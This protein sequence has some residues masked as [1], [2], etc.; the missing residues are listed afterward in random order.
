LKNWALFFVIL[1]YFSKE[2]SG[3]G[4]WEGHGPPLKGK[5]GGQEG[6]GGEGM[7]R[8][9]GNRPKSGKTKGRSFIREPRCKRGN[10]GLLK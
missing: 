7:T 5:E 1:K 4:K 2:M 10:A 3:D 9:P 6:K 8:S